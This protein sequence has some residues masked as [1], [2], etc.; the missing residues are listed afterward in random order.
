MRSVCRSFDAND[1]GTIDKEELKN[2]INEMRGS[3]ARMTDEEADRLI[4]MCDKNDSGTIDYKELLKHC[5]GIDWD[6]D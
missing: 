5:F 4:D 3:D 6:E 1:D 2:A